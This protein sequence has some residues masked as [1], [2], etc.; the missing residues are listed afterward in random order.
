MNVA[1]CFA[2]KVV[3]RCVPDFDRSCGE[4]VHLSSD[5]VRNVDFLSWCNQPNICLRRTL[6]RISF[7]DDD[8]PLPRR[9]ACMVPV[10]KTRIWPS[11]A[12]NP[13]VDARFLTSLRFFFPGPRHFARVWRAF[14]KTSLDPA[15]THYY[16]GREDGSYVGKMHFLMP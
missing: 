8:P 6:P 7:T 2:E 4:I 1:P 3:T 14:W 12:C 16:F 11:D 15:Y 9:D 13:A 10:A 5:H